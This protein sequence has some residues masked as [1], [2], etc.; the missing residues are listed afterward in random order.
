MGRYYDPSTAQFISV[1]PAVAQTGEP[2]AYADDDPANLSDPTGDSWYNPASWNWGTVGLGTGLVVLTA[3][4]VAQLG[5]DPVTDGLE[6]ADVAA[7]TTEAGL[8]TTAAVTAEIADAAEE[9]TGAINTG[10]MSVYT[11][12]NDEGDTNYV[13]IT[14]SIERR[15][16]EQLAEKGINI[17]PID[18]LEDLSREDARSVEQ[19]LIKTM[20]APGAANLSTKLTASR[21]AIRSTHNP[22]S[23]AANFRLPSEGRHRMSVDFRSEK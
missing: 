13:G 3:L 19:A 22:F 7:L 2:Y 9:G 6:V 8:D 14:N 16:G 18:G 10:D 1:D 21:R 5:A 11:S 23:G 17:R 12:V 4:N 20:V 15:A